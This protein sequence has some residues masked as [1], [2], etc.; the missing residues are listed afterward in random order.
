MD[1]T[2]FSWSHEL[3]PKLLFLADYQLQHKKTHRKKRIISLHN[4]QIPPLYESRTHI[5]S[6]GE[7]HQFRGL[8]P[9][10]KDDIG[11]FLDTSPPQAHLLPCNSPL[12][13]QI[14]QK[15]TYLWS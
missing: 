13:Q 4:L 9:I 2:K 15:D 8:Q 3:A 6:E 5:I 10:I 14:C 12:I 1:H 7:P 11:I